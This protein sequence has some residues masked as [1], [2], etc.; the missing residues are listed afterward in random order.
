VVLFVAC[1]T[2]QSSFV[3]VRDAK[4]DLARPPCRYLLKHQVPEV[5]V[6]RRAGQALEFGTTVRGRVTEFNPHG[7]ILDVGEVKPAFLHVSELEKEH[8]SSA[9]EF[10][11]LGQSLDVC[12][13]GENQAEI[14]V[15]LRKQGCKA[16]L[17]FKVGEEVEGQ[18]VSVDRRMA[19]VDVGAA[20]DAV[21]HE[22]HLGDKVNGLIEL[23]PGTKV[24]AKIRQV[25]PH[26]I[27]LTMRDLKQ[28]EDF[29]VGQEVEGK[30]VGMNKASLFV[31]I[32]AVGDAIIQKDQADTDEPLPKSFSMGEI[33]IANVMSISPQGI[34]LTM[35]WADRRSGADFKVG[36]AVEGHVVGKNEQGSFVDIGALKHALVGGDAGISDE[37]FHPDLGQ[38]VKAEVQDIDGE[39]IRLTKAQ[40]VFAAS[41]AETA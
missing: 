25:S 24:K 37:P 22:D 31:D 33:V 23:S 15:S 32:G 34:Q 17:Q 20:V 12:I 2:W 28:L 6:R 10:L 1:C 35:R 29:R 14:K 4:N 3:G 11:S 38:K 16:N 21:L 19:F 13:I 39:S 18:V 30:V 36:Q 5:L 40:V 9:E 26:R 7:A 41:A 27:R 8:T